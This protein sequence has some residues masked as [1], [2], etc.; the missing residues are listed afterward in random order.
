[1][2]KA[3]GVPWMSFHSLRHSFATH[4]AAQGYAATSIARVLGHSDSNFTQ[5][6]YIHQTDTVR[7]DGAFE[8]SQS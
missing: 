8:E 4:L 5:R 6:T 3:A 2:T 1:M 7:F